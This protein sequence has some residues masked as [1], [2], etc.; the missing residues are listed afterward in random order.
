[1]AVPALIL[2]ALQGGETWARNAH[3]SWSHAGPRTVAPRHV[4]VARPVRVVPRVVYFAPVIGYTAPRYY[5]PPPYYPPTS[6][7]SAPEPAAYA[8]PPAAYAPPPASYYEPPQTQYPPSSGNE[9]R[10]PGT[11]TQ[12]PVGPYSVEQGLNY[13]YFCPD[14]RQYYPEVKECASGWLTVVPNAGRPPR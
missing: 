1:M 10:A 5:A 7:Y 14:T 2:A 13:R 12:T 6:Y 11:A 3:R 8:P 9:A 4:F